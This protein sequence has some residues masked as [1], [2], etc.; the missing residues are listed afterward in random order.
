MMAAHAPSTERVDPSPHALERWTA[1]TPEDAPPIRA[2]WREG[3]DV[4]LPEPAYR[5]VDRGRYHRPT[6]TVLLVNGDRIRT[7]LL[8]DPEEIDSWKGVALRESV[9]AQFD[10]DTADRTVS[11][12]DME[13]THE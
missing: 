8:M 13:C 1:R 4:A 5:N 10:V 7:V 3:W 11:Y 2:A 9:E 6:N 12:R